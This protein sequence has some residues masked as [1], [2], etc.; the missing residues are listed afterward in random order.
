MTE[1][2]YEIHHQPP[3]ET[4]SV[5]S[6]GISQEGLQRNCPGQIRPQSFSDK[7][8]FLFAV[9]S[10]NLCSILLTLIVG[11]WNVVDVRPANAHFS[12]LDVVV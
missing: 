1:E 11:I 4:L 10:N 8:P 6:M 2:I 5:L 7:F 12:V 9:L 3:F